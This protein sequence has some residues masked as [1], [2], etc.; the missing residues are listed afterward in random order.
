MNSTNLTLWQAVEKTPVEQTKPITGKSYSGNSPKPHHLVRR[1]TETFGPCGIG[2]GFKVLEERI[3]EAATYA[4]GTPERMHY[5]KVQVWY[6]WGGQR[7]EVEHVGGTILS[8]RRKAGE[9]VP[10]T[11]DDAPKKSVTD[12]LVK[13]LSMIGFA[14]DIFLGRYDDSKYMAELRQ[15]E[16]VAK[17]AAAA[18]Q[19]PPERRQPPKAPAQHSAPANGKARAGEAPTQPNDAIPFGE[20]GGEVLYVN[21]QGR[22]TPLDLA[23]AVSRLEK[24]AEA[25]T[26][27]P[28]EEFAGLMNA[29]AGWLTNRAPAALKALFNARNMDAADWLR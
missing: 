5:A 2:W 17:K 8:G 26:S 29:N 24:A 1:A 18:P 16:Q 7:G 14:G 6:M 4:D 27:L 28:D 11:D 23:D 20:D 15:E 22:D 3:I 13:A 10:F 9:G 19:S 12:A 21:T 25:T